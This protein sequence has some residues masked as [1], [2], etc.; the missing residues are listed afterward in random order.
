MMKQERSFQETALQEQGIWEK[1]GP[2]TVTGEGIYSF[3]KEIIPGDYQVISNLATSTGRLVEIEAGD[4]HS[5][6]L[7]TFLNKQHPFLV[8]EQKQQRSW[9]LL[10]EAEAA[11]KAQKDWMP[12]DKIHLGVVGVREH[13]DGEIGL[14]SFGEMEE[15]DEPGLLMRLIPE[16]DNLY[17]K[18]LQDPHEIRRRI[19]KI[20]EAITLSQQPVS[21]ELGLE[22]AGA[23][24]I[25]NWIDGGN[26]NVLRNHSDK[27]MRGFA[28]QF[29]EEF[30]QFAVS[31]KVLL[32]SR[33]LDYKIALGSGDTKPLNAFAVGEEVGFID[34][35]RL[36]LKAN[37][38]QGFTY[39]PWPIR[40]QISELAYFT[41]F[42]RAAEEMCDGIQTKDYAHLRLEMMKAYGERTDDDYD[43]E[44]VSNIL[45]FHEAALASVEI[46]ISDALTQKPGDMYDRLKSSL[47]IVAKK[48][49][50]EVT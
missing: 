18:L 50:E 35:I 5:F 31:N 21:V 39:A 41:V 1:F 43:S 6:A 2:F 16:E 29:W 8:F 7:K 40:D 19:P 24:G 20:V 47:M 9:S 10:A 26:L 42:I 12:E 23:Q 27:N 33:A 3:D 49:L 4:N 32:D 30:S 46:Q 38:E 44:D 36:F 25:L 11:M 45:A 48:A 17:E 28:E 14:V 13:A 34:P 22:L 15:S 37:N